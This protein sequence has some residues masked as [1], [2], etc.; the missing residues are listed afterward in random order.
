MI[1]FICLGGANSPNAPLPAAQ[2]HRQALPHAGLI[3]PTV[4]QGLQH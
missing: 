2:P 3:L 1:V 4:S